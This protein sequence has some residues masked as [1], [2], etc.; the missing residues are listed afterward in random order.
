MTVDTIISH[1]CT[2]FTGVISVS[3]KLDR[4]EMSRHLLT[5]MVRDQGVP[6]KKGFARVEIDVEDDNDHIPQFVSTTFEG[7]VFETAAVGSS[8]LQVVAM[9]QDKGSNSELTY[10]IVSGKTSN[11][12]CYIIVI[13]IIIVMMII[14]RRRRRRRRR[15][16]MII[17]MVMIIIIMIIVVMSV[18]LEHLSTWNMLSCA[19]QGQIQK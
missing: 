14:R 19:E 5:I 4:E 17:I 18:F 3:E 1:L 12:A 2:T 7:R 11:W 8:V 9:D 10:S 16:M 6:A 15:M 13:I